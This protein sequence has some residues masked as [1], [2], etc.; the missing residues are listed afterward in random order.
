MKKSSF[1]TALLR[2]LSDYGM[3]LVLILLCAFFSWAT[4]NEQHPNGVS[5]AKRLVRYVETEHA[6]ALRIL[7]VAGRGE[8][9]LEFAAECRRQFT[10]SGKTVLDVVNGQP[11]DARRAMERF[12][13]A[14]GI[15]LI[16]CNHAVAQWP[17][18]EN[19][20]GKI[21][22]LAD[23]KIAAPPTY[24]W[25]DFLKRDNLL[26]LPNQ[27]VV[28][29]VI[30]IGMTLVIITAGID[31]SVGSLIALSAVVATL[32]IEGPGGGAKAGPTIIALC[33]IA[34]IGAC[35]LV[36][37]FTGVMV[38]LFRIPPFI[39]TLAMMLVAR[40]FAYIFS[41]GQTIHEIPASIQWLGKG[42]IGEI[43]VAVLLMVALYVAAHI[44]M[45]YTTFGR[46][47]YAV[48]GN[49]EAARLS[50]VP[51][52]RTLLIVYVICGALAGLGGVITASQLGAGSAR[53]GEWF[54]LYVIAAVVV[55]GA[56]L[57]GGEG[58]ILGTLIGA[59]IIAVIRNGMNLTGVEAYTQLVVL[60]FVILG[61]VLLDNL[62]KHGRKLFGPG[63]L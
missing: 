35:A 25:P 43:P 46:R 15:D 54:E 31:L 36:G 56:S 58:K 1:H 6:K 48:G 59:F 21:P 55:G 24:M 3:L 11:I 26:N 34:G 5:G 63:P 9:D 49:P 20:G 50:G 52:R 38:T 39:A 22:R 53:Y 33:C 8:E 30:A 37:L 29:A 47:V 12:A 60:G 62:K 4:W 19:L 18:F 61:A 32:L 44:V 27:I 16:A 57:L 10:E 23:T 17:L 51:V 28:I 40:G 45:T 7:V 41:N 42:S 14:G 2:S 13:A